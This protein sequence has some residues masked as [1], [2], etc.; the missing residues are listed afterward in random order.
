MENAYK[1]LD[2][3]KGLKSNHILDVVT[4]RSAILPKESIGLK[5]QLQK[6]ILDFCINN[7]FITPVS[8]E[9][10]KSKISYSL[11]AARKLYVRRNNK[12]ID[13]IET[14]HV[15]HAFLI[16]DDQVLSSS[17]NL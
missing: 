13:S 14:G 4:I 12:K 17:F 6:T 2:I 16:N 3:I 7:G 9:G 5:T 10:K 8:S 1:I 11:V 15:H